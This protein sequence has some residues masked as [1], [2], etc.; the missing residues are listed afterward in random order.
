MRGD[1]RGDRIN[2]GGLFAEENTNLTGHPAT[3]KIE[4]WTIEIQDKT[5]NEFNDEGKSCKVPE[6][7]ESRQKKM[8]AM[9]EVIK[10]DIDR[11]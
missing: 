6:S 5:D 4:L 8:D 3:E 9:D 7:E 2:R 10:D 1:R 11:L